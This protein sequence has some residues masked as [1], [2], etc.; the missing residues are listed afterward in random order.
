MQTLSCSEVRRAVWS[1]RRA[2]VALVAAAASTATAASAWL[3][4]GR[5]GDLASPM[6][7]A[8]GG[9]TGTV[10]MAWLVTVS[11]VT[12]VFV[13]IGLLQ[14]IA[15]LASRPD[16][17]RCLHT[18]AS[19]PQPQLQPRP[20]G[21]TERTATISQLDKRPVP[22]GRA[23][24]EVTHAHTGKLIWTYTSEGAA[25]GFVRDVVRLRSH[26]D[27]AQFQLRMVIGA[28]GTTTIADGEELVR[29]ALEDRVL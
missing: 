1:R 29:R 14:L 12:A 4:I 23:M 6:E 21:R 10:L 26:H 16:D 11:T 8:S 24:F 17:C 5:V 7:E 15:E 25:L 9:P 19:T 2:V 13:V 28:T 22:A 27:A 18:V 3:M 20:Q